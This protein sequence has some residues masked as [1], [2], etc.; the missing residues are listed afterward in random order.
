[1]LAKTLVTI[2]L[3]ATGCVGPAGFGQPAYVQSSAVYVP[4]PAQAAPLAQRRVTFNGGHLDQRGLSAL[5]RVEAY[6]GGQLPDGDYWYDR[7]SGAAGTWGGP[8]AGFIGPNLPLGGALPARASG[9]G[10]GVYVNGREIHVAEYRWLAGLM[11]RPPMR[12]R[13]WLDANGD[14]GIEGGARLGNLAAAARTRGGNGGNG[15]NGGGSAGGR[16]WSRYMPG[17]S[18]RPGSGI[19]MASDGQTTCVNTANY[20]RCY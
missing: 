2:A 12:G 14:V 18:S 13:Y 7:R 8:P 19:G 1:M 17:V 15:G 11:G 16:S 6:Y 5:A 3:L 4:P 9:G 10:T 20:T